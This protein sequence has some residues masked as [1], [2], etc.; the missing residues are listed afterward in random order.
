MNQCVPSSSNLLRL[1]LI[2]AGLIITG[3]LTAQNLVPN[4]SFENNTGC[5]GGWSQLNLVNNWNTP[6]L[7]SPDYFHTCATVPDMGVP[8]NTPGYTQAHTGNGYVGITTWT[9][10]FSFPGTFYFCEYIQAQLTAP[11]LAGQ[12]YRVS[13]WANCA[14]SN[15][16]LSAGDPLIFGISSLV[17]AY[18]SVTPPSTTG[19]NVLPITGAPQITSVTTVDDTTQWTLITGIY[20]ATG[21]E[22]YITIGNWNKALYG[23]GPTN[24]ISMFEPSSAY[25]YIDDVEI[26][27]LPPLDLGADDL[28]CP[29]ETITISG[30]ANA[31]SYQWSNGESSTFI[32]ITAPGTYSLIQTTGGCTQ[33]DT[34]VINEDNCPTPAPSLACTFYIPNAFTPDK[35]GLNDKFGPEGA[36]IISFKMAIFNRWGEKIFETADMNLKWDGTMNGNKCQED[37]YVYS[38]TYLCANGEFFKTGHVSLIR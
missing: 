14:E 11:L 15:E 37:V 3:L 8:A 22:Q 27:A 32:S 33:F 26:T 19:F 35:N 4:A 6:S 17:S 16:S 28:I 9:D 1:A 30:S 2:I 20:T 24:S 13:F 10:T 21:G 31:D 7:G 5:P 34:I 23:N 12:C 25:Y 29:G 36:E 18:I 38:V